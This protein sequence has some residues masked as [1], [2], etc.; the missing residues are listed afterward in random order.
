[1]AED[2]SKSGVSW[3]TVVVLLAAAGGLFSLPSALRTSRPDEEPRTHNSPTRSQ[4]NRDAHVA[5]PFEAV[6]D[7][8]KEHG[9]NANALT[10]FWDDLGNQVNHHIDTNHLGTNSIDAR[11]IILPVMVPG[12]PNVE[13]AEHRQRS[14]YAVLSGLAV[15]GYVPADESHLG[16][17]VVEWPEG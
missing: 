12:G 11:L 16:F 10:Q 4:Q 9:T 1:M 7:Y 8:L 15:S 5:R 17:F 6:H 3:Q 2:T 13:D 14:R